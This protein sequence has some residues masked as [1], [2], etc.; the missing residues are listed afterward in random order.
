MAAQAAGK[1][2]TATAHKLHASS[3]TFGLQD[4]ERLTQEEAITSNN[5]GNALSR[6]F[7]KRAHALG[8]ELVHRLSVG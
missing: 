4:K 3:I 7:R 8:I 5:T 1:A 2:I 6:I